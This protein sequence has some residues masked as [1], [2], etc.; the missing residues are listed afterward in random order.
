MGADVL[1]NGN[2]ITC[3][4][5]GNI[6][7]YDPATGAEIAQATTSSG[8]YV[9]DIA[10]IPDTVGGVDR[11]FGVRSGS[12]VEFK[13]GTASNIIGY[14]TTEL[15]AAK[16]DTSF[17][18]R[19]S[20]AY[21]AHDNTLIWTN[22]TDDKVYVWDV[23]SGT[24]VQVLSNRSATEAFADPSGVLVVDGGDG[25]QYLIVS[26]FWGNLT[27]YR[28]AKTYDMGKI[29]P[30]PT[31]DGTMA[32][33]EWG[34][35]TPVCTDFSQ[36]GAPL[37]AAAEDLE[38]TVLYDDT[39]MYFG[40]QQ[41]NSNF[42][43]AF[44]PTG[45]PRDPGGVS[46]AGDDYNL[47]LY[48]GGPMATVG[49]HIVSSPTRRTASATFGMKR[50]LCLDGRERPAG[51]AAAIRRLSAMCGI[52]TIEYRIPWTALNL[53]GAPVNTV[54]AMIRCGAFSWAI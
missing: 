12:L 43:L 14:S 15:I 1:S 19:P 3:K 17:Q 13:G 22:M 37:T 49:Y 23:A 8:N 48:P 31:I 24:E 28:S 40:I 30:A 21:S 36:N 26:S 4:F 27:V 33:G 52:L 41:V 6:I 44:T 38:V 5:T 10:V 46:F 35:G 42:A 7:A 9:R 45:G 18:V 25:Y 2:V 16:G 51:T 50:A 53:A 20:V 54:P 47:F 11:I 39:Y 34:E 29:T 32:A